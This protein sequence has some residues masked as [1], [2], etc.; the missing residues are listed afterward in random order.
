[1]AGALAIG[2][3]IMIMVSPLFGVALAALIIGIALL[4]YGIRLVVTGISGRRGEAV[5]STVSP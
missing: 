3:S 5:T 2:L 1:M 4:V